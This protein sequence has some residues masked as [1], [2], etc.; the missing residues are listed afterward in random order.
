MMVSLF[1][2]KAK[3]GRDAA[4][5]R[6]DYWKRLQKKDPANRQDVRL[7]EQGDMATLEFRI[8]VVVI[9]LDYRSLNA[10]WVRDG[11]WVDLHISRGPSGPDDQA[12]FEN[13]LATARFEDQPQP[14][15]ANR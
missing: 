15:S 10:M 5:Y 11:V 14:A 7:R 2:E 12:L 4:E 9:P 6:D 3:P 8:K 1:L 13:I